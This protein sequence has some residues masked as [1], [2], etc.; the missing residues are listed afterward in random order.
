VLYQLA[1][2]VQLRI[3]GLN[4]MLGRT[5]V[6]IGAAM[7]LLAV[8]AIWGWMRK[9]A[10]SA[11]NAINWTQPVNGQPVNGQPA[12]NDAYGQSTAANPNPAYAAYSDTPG[13]PY[14]TTV[15]YAPPPEP[16]YA[17]RDYVRTIRPSA[18]QRQEY[19]ERPPV[20]TGYAERGAADRVHYTRER[21]KRNSALIVAGSAGTGAAIG[22]LAGGGKGAGI[23]AL[24][25]GAGGFIYDR[26]T[27]K[28]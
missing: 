22:A 28:H 8:F 1:A 11:T 17:S 13:N 18:E 15:S 3:G 9:P 12:T 25:G 7:A 4:E 6:L 26:L 21:S 16:M 5:K 10:N 19:V 20:E 23:G 27:H 2:R 14:A 24:A